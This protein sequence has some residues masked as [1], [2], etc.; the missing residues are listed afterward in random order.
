MEVT[1]WFRWLIGSLVSGW[2]SRNCTLIKSGREGSFS[3]RFL[4]DSG[5]LP[6]NNAHLSF[7][8]FLLLAFGVIDSKSVVM[9]IVA[10]DAASRVCSSV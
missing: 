9:P 3:R 2:C 1:D 10:R 4:Q 7:I 6:P 5:Y 8:T